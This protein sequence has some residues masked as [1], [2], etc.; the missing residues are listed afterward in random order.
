MTKEELAMK[1]GLTFVLQGKFW[2]M[3]D[4]DFNRKVDEESIHDIFELVFDE[5]TVGQL[6]NILEKID[7]RL[8]D[9]LRKLGGVGFD[10]GKIPDTSSPNG[11]LTLQ[12]LNEQLIRDHANRKL[13]P[14]QKFIRDRGATPSIP[15]V[16]QKL[17]YVTRQVNQLVSAQA[18][19]QVGWL[20][21]GELGKKVNRDGRTILKW[22][23]L[24][25]FPER[26]IKKVSRGNGRFVYRLQAPE[27]IELAHGILIGETK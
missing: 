16:E 11:G 4:E 23:E 9:R 5:L 24:G 13:I 15:Q 8:V 10:P 12:K 18:S 20:S 6:L 2:Q 19:N 21:T 3:L 1:V 17:D 26:V 22:I 7:S 27:A 14:T 25:K